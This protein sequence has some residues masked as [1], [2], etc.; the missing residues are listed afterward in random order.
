[1]GLNV[2]ELN[3]KELIFQNQALPP[4]TYWTVYLS[5]LD[6]LAKIDPVYKR[7]LSP[8]NYPIQ[9]YERR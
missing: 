8:Q 1:M 7:R 6:A 2:A 5:V 4:N 9:N 3:T